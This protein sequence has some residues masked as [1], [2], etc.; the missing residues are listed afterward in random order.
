M[1]H[2]WNLAIR[3]SFLCQR[4]HRIIDFLG[5]GMVAPSWEDPLLWYETNVSKKS[6]LLETIRNLDSLEKYVRASTPE[7]YGSSDNFISEKQ[8]FNP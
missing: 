1:I 2:L 8:P 5:Q 3:L 6:L 4:K 7:V